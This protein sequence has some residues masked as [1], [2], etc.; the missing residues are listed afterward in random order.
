MTPLVLPPPASTERSRVLPVD[1]LRREALA[2]LY[3]RRD[4]VDTLI[5][6]LEDYQRS[7]ARAG[8]IC[9]DI[10]ARR[11]CSSN[12]ARLQI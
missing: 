3:Q 5:R 6:S 8:A 9:V 12:S 1:D 4:T 10:T 7:Q 2:R 11:K